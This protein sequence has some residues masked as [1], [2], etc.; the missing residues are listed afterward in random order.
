MG[1]YVIDRDECIACGPCKD[2]CPVDAIEDHDDWYR[3]DQDICIQC[4][5][6][7]SVCPID[8]ITYY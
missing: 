5:Q 6:C 2:S 8:C 1:V 4:G 7:Q 3:I